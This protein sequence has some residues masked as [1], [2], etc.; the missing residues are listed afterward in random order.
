MTSIHSTRNHS[1]TRPGNKEH[2]LLRMCD[3]TRPVSGKYEGRMKKCSL[4]SCYNQ[5]TKWQ[6]MQVAFCRCQVKPAS[7]HQ[8]KEAAGGRPSLRPP[9]EG[10]PGRGPPRSGASSDH[11]WYVGCIV[12]CI[13]LLLLPSCFCWANISQLV[14]NKTFQLVQ[15]KN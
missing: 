4:F 5:T 3:V 9:F 12:G 2:L 11:P 7:M 13:A 15:N 6:K 14:Q 10:C 8:Y 1:N